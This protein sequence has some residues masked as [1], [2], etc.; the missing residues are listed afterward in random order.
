MRYIFL[1]LYLLVVGIH[2]KDSFKDDKRA[3]N[4]WN[5]NINMEDDYNP[6]NCRLNNP[7]IDFK[8]VKI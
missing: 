1:C 8:Y 4:R 5:S 6:R 7:R 3:R 2:L